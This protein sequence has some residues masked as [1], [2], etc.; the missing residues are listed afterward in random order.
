[1]IFDMLKRL[2]SVV[3]LPNDY[4]CKKVSVVG[5]MCLQ[6]PVRVSAHLAQLPYRHRGGRAKC[7]QSPVHT[8]EPTWQG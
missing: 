4:V 2:R 7:F 5:K 1:M 8:E 3:Y 6:G